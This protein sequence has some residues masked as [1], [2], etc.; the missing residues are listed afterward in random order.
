MDERRIDEIARVLAMG[1]GRRRVVGG[2]ATALLGGLARHRPVLAACKR[3]GHN[4][5]RNDD[6]C[7][8]AT[9][10]LGECECKNG[11]DKCDGKC[12][13]LDTDEKHCGRCSK[14]CRGGETCRNGSCDGDDGETGPCGGQTCAESEECVGGV[15]TTPSGGCPVGA[16]S[17][18]AGGYLPCGGGATCV[19]LQSTE[20]TTHCGEQDTPGAI[21]GQCE[22]SADCASFGDGAFCAT[23]CCPGEDN[24]CRLPCA[25]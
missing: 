18:V 8:H 22:S 4:C 24:W 20:G 10:K 19:C 1:F 21:C 3:V 15:C 16:N 12:F 2:L 9:C 14:K 7:D 6:C 23:T 13:K 11:F 5:D 25:G 17:C